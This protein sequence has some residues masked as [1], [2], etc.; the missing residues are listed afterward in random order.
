LQAVRAAEFYVTREG[1][2]PAK[3]L[4]NPMILIGIVSVGGML[5]MP[6]LLENS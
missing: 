2:N 4:S 6:K 1:F 5:L 3:L